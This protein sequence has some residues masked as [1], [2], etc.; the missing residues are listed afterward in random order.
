MR[1]FILKVIG[2]IFDFDIETAMQLR[3]ADGYLAGVRDGNP[4]GK[5]ADYMCDFVEDHMD[6]FPEFLREAR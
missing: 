5:H 1:R 6:E 2:L 3:Y 4:L